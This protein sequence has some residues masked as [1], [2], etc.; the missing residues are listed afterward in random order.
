[1]HLVL[2][3]PHDRPLAAS[4][5]HERS[6][7]TSAWLAWLVHMKVSMLVPLDRLHR[8]LASQGIELAMSTLVGVN[9]RGADLLEAI[10]GHHRPL[11]LAGAWMATDRTGLKVLVP[12]LKAAQ[13]S[14]RPV[15]TLKPPPSPDH[16]DPDPEPGRDLVLRLLSFIQDPYDPQTK[17]IRV[18]SRHG[19][20][21]CREERSLVD[22]R[23][24]RDHFFGIDLRA[25]ESQV[26]ETFKEASDDRVRALDEEPRPQVFEDEDTD[27]GHG[28]VEVRLVRVADCFE[29]VDSRKL[30]K[31]RMLIVWLCEGRLFL[32]LV[33]RESRRPCSS[34]VAR[35]RLRARPLGSCVVTGPCRTACTGSSTWLWAKIRRATGHETSPPT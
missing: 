5:P 18:C 24:Y 34:R 4:P 1:M 11:R 16:R 22:P 7:V 14:R 12:T 33:G 9:E 3:G 32:R 15:L 10:N 21:S 20:T 30:S 17:I 28:R 23:K 6:K 2:D 13:G 29:W 31:G 8:D 19:P 25:A 35:S 26:A 27:K